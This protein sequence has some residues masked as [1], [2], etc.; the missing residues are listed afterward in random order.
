VHPC[1]TT[2]P[3]CLFRVLAR[4]LLYISLFGT[5]HAESTVLR[6]LVSAVAVALGVE[7]RD[8]DVVLFRT[9]EA[10]VVAVLLAAMGIALLTPLPF[11]L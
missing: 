3:H 9:I 7:G 4:R 10:I 6:S 8:L 5:S 11:G 1:V 2:C